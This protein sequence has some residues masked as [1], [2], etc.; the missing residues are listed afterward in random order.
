MNIHKLQMVSHTLL[1]SPLNV[2]P[3]EAKRNINQ[4]Y[5]LPPHLVCDNWCKNILPLS[6][7]LLTNPKMKSFGK[8]SVMSR[9]SKLF[10][11][12]HCYCNH[13]IILKMLSH[14]CLYSTLIPCKNG[15]LS[16]AQDYIDQVPNLA[17]LIFLNS[18]IWINIEILKSYPGVG[19]WIL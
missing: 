10:F 6:P 19:I 11:L 14:I 1:Q 18:N 12:T 15:N 13:T 8:V 9:V 17:L 3:H 5:W 7:F 2:Q 4:T 16:Q